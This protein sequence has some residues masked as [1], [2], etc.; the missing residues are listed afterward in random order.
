MIVAA[1][2][3]SKKAGAREEF[4]IARLRPPLSRA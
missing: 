3:F 4:R 1:G 2:K